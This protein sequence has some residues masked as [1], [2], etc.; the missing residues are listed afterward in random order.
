MTLLTALGLL[1]FAFHPQFAQNGK[2]Y[3]NYT[4]ENMRRSVVSEFQVSK[5]NPSKADMGSDFLSAIELL[6]V[7]VEN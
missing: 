2:F 3:V 7:M 5:E 1:S 4:R 6:K